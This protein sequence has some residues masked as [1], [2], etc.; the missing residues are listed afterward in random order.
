MNMEA[1]MRMDEA[2]KLRRGVYFLRWQFGGGS[3]ATVGSLHDGTPWFAPCDWMRATPADI[4]CTAWKLVF[5]AELVVPI[6]DVVLKSRTTTKHA[7]VAGG[8]RRGIASSQEMPE[9]VTIPEGVDKQIEA[10]KPPLAK[11]HT[12]P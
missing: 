11:Q 2:K 9:S 6:E 4:A 12:R 1:Q 10:G 3:H 5:R 7:G 8:E